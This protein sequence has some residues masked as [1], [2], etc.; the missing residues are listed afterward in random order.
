MGR[1]AQAWL[2]RAIHSLS[3]NLARKFQPSPD[4]VEAS[5][6]PLRGPPS[7]AVLRPRRK[8]PS[9]SAAG[10]ASAAPLRD[11]C[12]P[13]GGP[14][15]DAGEVSC[16]Q[17]GA[18]RLREVLAVLRSDLGS[19]Q[20]LLAIKHGR[21]HWQ[22]LG[23]CPRMEAPS[24]IDQ[25]AVGEAARMRQD[26]TQLVLDK[27]AGTPPK[28]P[29]SVQEWVNSLPADEANKPSPSESI[30]RRDGGCPVINP[31]VPGNDD[32]NLTLGAEARTLGSSSLLQPS[33]GK[34]MLGEL[35]SKQSSFNSETS[36][37]S[38][39]S[40]MSSVESL[41]EARREDPEELLLALG[42]GGQEADPVARIPER[43]LVQ[44]SQARGVDLRRLVCHQETLSQR[45]DTGIP[46]PMHSG[47]PPSAIASK[48]MEA[49]EQ[50]QK[51]RSFAATA[52]LAR[53]T[54]SLLLSSASRGS[55]ESILEP[56]NREFL[57]RQGAEDQEPDR[58]KLVLGRETFSFDL[59]SGLV[60]LTSESMRARWRRAV[61]RILARGT[62]SAP[63]SPGADREARRLCRQS[64]ITEEAQ[65]DEDSGEHTLTELSNLHRAL[66]E[67]KARHAQ[68]S[69]SLAALARG[70][71]EA[72][73]DLEI[74][75]QLR[76]AIVDEVRRAESLLASHQ[77]V[78]L[79]SL[80]RQECID[81]HLLKGKMAELLDLQRELC[82]Q[83]EEILLLGVDNGGQDDGMSLDAAAP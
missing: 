20:K 1:S 77:M 8:A 63:E 19:E 80:P 78:A 56:A 15:G 46:A 41:L 7:E 4:V 14:P 81:Y 3:P 36:G 23:A 65:P 27:G 26:T 38:T 59:D 74:V 18:A 31:E 43:F 54:S 21:D 52:K 70:S 71:Q 16:E 64:T 35:R 32:D 24:P 33:S 66:K 9:E 47:T 55:S 79:V 37:F 76:E 57:E 75:G 25:S 22:R 50:N 29:T 44:P 48:I 45:H 28:S 40:S 61:R 69:G 5:C 62:E 51:S 58:K 60:L 68:Y 17:Y 30:M 2:S 73:P 11:H 6:R 10:E 39:I 53:A 12:L 72:I 42:F 83:I 82:S 34:A 13:Y 67:Y 49:M